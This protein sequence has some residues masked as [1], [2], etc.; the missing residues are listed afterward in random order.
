MLVVILHPLASVA[1]IVKLFAVSPVNTPFVF[2]VPVGNKE[3]VIM[4]L[5][6]E[7]LIEIVAS[8]A[9]LHCTLVL[10]TDVQSTGVGCVIRTVVL[11]VH[12][13]ASLACMV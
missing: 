12:P 10:L 4:P 3:Y 13:F 1:C 6:P 11:V 5:P 2:D 7:A 8:E 9:P